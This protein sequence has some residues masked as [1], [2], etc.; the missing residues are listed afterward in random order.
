[1]AILLD[2]LIFNSNKKGSELSD[3]KILEA[4][5][6]KYFTKEKNEYDAE[7][8]SE[9]NYYFIN[10]GEKEMM[11]AKQIKINEYNID[12]NRKFNFFEDDDI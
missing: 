6:N 9:F 5:I 12:I 11:K 3:K 8:Y 10:E 7:V 4:K 2:F 1:M